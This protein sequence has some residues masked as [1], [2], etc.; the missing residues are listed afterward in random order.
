MGTNINTNTSL[1]ELSNLI[2]QFR[3]EET[4]DERAERIFECVEDHED[5]ESD[6]SF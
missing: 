2:A 6:S 5:Y 4:E 3:S 1:V